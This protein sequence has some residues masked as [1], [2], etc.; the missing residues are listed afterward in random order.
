MLIC[1]Y[2]IAILESIYLYAKKKKKKRTQSRL[3][4]LL[5]KCVYKSYIFNIYVLIGFV[6]E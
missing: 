2:D 1:D 5:T 6:I 3:R 4:I